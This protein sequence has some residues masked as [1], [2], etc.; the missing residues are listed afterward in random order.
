MPANIFQSA[1]QKGLYLGILFS[2]NFLLSTFKNPILSLLTYA[3]IG[4]IVYF[5]HKFTSSFRD[6]ENGGILSYRK[7]FAYI[8]LLFLFASIISAAV[9]YIYFTYINPDFL[10][11]MFN[12]NMLLLEQVMP[13]VPQESYDAIETMTSPINYTLLASWV[14]LF[15]GFVF[16]L[17]MAGI[18]KRDKPAFP[19]K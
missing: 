3:V 4:L 15:V 8:I 9:K 18:S 13:N 17:I 16:G 7:G 10:S 19:T 6:N 14:N 1:M 2:V 12:Q 11:N 5:V